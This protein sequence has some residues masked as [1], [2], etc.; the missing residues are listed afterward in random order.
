MLA[1]L[2]AACTGT[3][4]IDAEP[5]D[6]RAGFTRAADGL[7]YEAEPADDTA[8][9][10]TDTAPADADGDGYAAADDCD[11][12]RADVYPG[13][14]E[15]C[16]GVNNDC[17]GLTDEVGEV[18]WYRDADGD[19]YGVATETAYACAAPEGFVGNA[20]DCDDGRADT[21]PGATDDTMDGF[22]QDCDGADYDPC[23]TPSGSAEFVHDRVRVTEPGTVTM[24]M[25]GDA[26]LCSFTCDS[27]EWVVA[28][29]WAVEDCEEN[30]KPPAPYTMPGGT[31]YLCAVVVEPSEPSDA[32]C[33]ARTSA[34]AR[35]VTLSWR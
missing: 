17:D 6:C 33:T 3:A 11:D 1:L 29:G 20:V 18:Y 16:D 2:L 26:V 28:L 4:T 9:D 13:A 25:E 12:T 5:R 15:L 8:P 22:D 24:H 30:P 23:G 7:C 31:T 10:D 35:T 19:G 14:E 32:T 27:E 21:Y 34:G